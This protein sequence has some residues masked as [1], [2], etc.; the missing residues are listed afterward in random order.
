MSVNIMRLP[1]DE[2]IVRVFGLNTA[3]GGR[4]LAADSIQNVLDGLNWFRCLS[5]QLGNELR[6]ARES[7]EHNRIFG[8]HA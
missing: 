6:E 5:V 3:H 7:A 1:F 2:E 4:P 8:S